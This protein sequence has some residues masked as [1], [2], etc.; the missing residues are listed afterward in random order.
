MVNCMVVT[1][2][3]RTHGNIQSILPVDGGLET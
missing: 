1:N 2:M 3:Q